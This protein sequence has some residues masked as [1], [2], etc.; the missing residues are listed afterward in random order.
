MSAS[1]I[2][3]TRVKF[4]QWECYIS[5]DHYFTGNEAIQLYDV[6]SGE[7]VLTASVNIPDHRLA[8]GTIAIKNYS[9]N[10]GIF[11]ILVKAKIVSEPLYYVK[12]GFVT[13][14]ICDLLV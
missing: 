3:A 2:L 7:P 8:A 14:P 6:E 1:R 10:E 11:D 12:S 13:I 9:E 4:K 5:I